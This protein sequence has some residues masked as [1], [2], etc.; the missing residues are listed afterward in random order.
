MPTTSEHTLSPDDILLWRDGL[1]CFREELCKEFLR[2]DNY[3]AI[4]QHSD[5][6]SSFTRNYRC[7]DCQIE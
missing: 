2:N 5:E 4:L 7:G 6:W 1:W 3:R